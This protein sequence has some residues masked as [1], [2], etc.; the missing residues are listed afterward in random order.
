MAYSYETDA[1]HVTMGSIDAGSLTCETPKIKQ[2]IY[3][4]EKAPWVMLP[5]D[6]AERWGTA[7]SAHLIAVKQE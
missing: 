6:G 7:E 2:H 5:D 4:S 1:I 3:L